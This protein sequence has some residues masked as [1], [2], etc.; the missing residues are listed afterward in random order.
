MSICNDSFP[1]HYNSNGNSESLLRSDNV[2]LTK[3]SKINTGPTIVPLSEN[4][5]PAKS[6]VRV[7]ELIHTHANEVIRRI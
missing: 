7:S 5:S 1:C 6:T 4:V 3:T 2:S